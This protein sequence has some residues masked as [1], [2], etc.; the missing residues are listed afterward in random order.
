MPLAVAHLD[1]ML[2][3]TIIFIIASLFCAFI[4]V[5]GR[6]IYVRLNHEH[7]RISNEDKRATIGLKGFI[8]CPTSHG[9]LYDRGHHTLQNQRQHVSDTQNVEKCFI[10]ISDDSDSDMDAPPVSLFTDS[11]F[12]GYSISEK[13]GDFLV[14]NGIS[15]LRRHVLCPRHPG[16]SRRSQCSMSES[17]GNLDCNV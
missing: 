6:Y 5:T 8:D 15:L 12:Q 1:F 2:L 17:Y 3:F 9:G 11:T 4:Y 14:T 10:G 16:C 7:R 13:G